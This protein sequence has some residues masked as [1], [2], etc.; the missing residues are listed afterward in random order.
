MGKG[1][2]IVWLNRLLYEL[3]F[4]PHVYHEAVQRTGSVLILDERVDFVSV[5][6]ALNLMRTSAAKVVS[7]VAYRGLHFRNFS[8]CFFCRGE[9]M[10]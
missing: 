10:L 4:E 7:I 8:H 9:Q 1:K 2:D 6:K 5:A 3:Q